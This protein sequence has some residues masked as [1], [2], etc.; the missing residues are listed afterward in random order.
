MD[1]AVPRLRVRP[2]RADPSFAAPPHIQ[3]W[4]GDSDSNRGSFAPEANG[5]PDFPI[6]R[7]ITRSPAP[8][9][10]ACPSLG[11]P[12]KLVGTVRVEL[13]HLR[14]PK[15]AAQPLAYV[16]KSLPLKPTI[17]GFNT[18]SNPK[19]CNYR[20]YLYWNYHRKE[21]LNSNPCGY[22]AQGSTRL[23]RLSRAPRATWAAVALGSNYAYTYNTGSQNV[24]KNYFC[25]PRSR[26][27]F[28]ARRGASSPPR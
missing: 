15:S 14:R 7:K 26:P 5:I 21:L 2:P 8:S 16:P 20:L 28:P 19:A 10:T 27:L 6:A 3:F 12:L 9:N 13:T 22:S 23:T 17:L 25:H 11:H 18:N 4:S 1:L 24:V